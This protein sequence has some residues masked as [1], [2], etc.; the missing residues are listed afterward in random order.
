[1]SLDWDAVATHLDALAA[2]TVWGEN[3]IPEPGQRHTLSAVAR[4]IRGGQRALLLAD[5]VGMG[6]TLIAAALITCVRDAGGRSAVVI[7]PGLGAQWQSE[8]RRFIP[9]DRTLSP[10]RSFWTFREGYS[11]P[12]DI[13]DKDYMRKRR[14]SELADRRQQRQLPSGTWRDEQ[15]LLLSHTFGRLV[16]TSGTEVEYQALIDAVTKVYAGTRRYRRDPAEYSYVNLSRAA[17][18]QILSGLSA[19]DRRRLVEKELPGCSV[20]EGVRHIVAK[21]LGPFDLIVIDEAHKSRGAESSLSRVIGKLV[22]KTAGAFHLGMTATPV[23]LDASQW[24]G[25]LDRLGVPEETLLV[26]QSA[27]DRYVEAV[28]QLQTRE[29]LTADAVDRFALVARD[30]QQTLSPWVLRRDKREDSFLASFCAAHGSHRD[31]SPVEVALADM[32]LEWK[33]A[34]IATE[35]L[36][37]LGEHQLSPHERR[38]RLSLPDGRGI[39]EVDGILDAGEVSPANARQRSW[40]GLANIVARGGY[41]A[42]Y[43]H[44]AILRATSE[45]ETAVSE[46]QKV[47]VFGRFTKPMRALT[48]LLDAREM[49]RR[50]SGADTPEN[51]WP[52]SKLGKLSEERD[53]ALQSALDDRQ[54]N[55]LGLGRDEIEARLDDRARIHES[56]RRSN[57]DAMRSEIQQLASG[58]PDGTAAALA[59]LWRPH[60]D[61]DIA[62]SNAALLAALENQRASEDQ[63]LPWTVDGLLNAWQGL[64]R[65]IAGSGDDVD[66]GAE[67]EARFQLHLEDFRGPE[68]H[69]ARLMYGDTA[70]QTRRLLQASFNRPGVAPQV[71]VVQSSVGR[72][73]L[74]LHTACRVVVMLHLE[75]NPAYMEQQIGRVDRID[76]LWSRDAHAFPKSGDD[77]EAAPR[78]SIRP[79]VV[80]GT[81]DDRHWAV[82]KSRWNSM[83]AQLNGEILPDV[84]C[85]PDDRA[86]EALI[87]QA[88]AAAPDFSPSPG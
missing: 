35:A 39:T 23:E 68:G 76:S 55:P 70:P 69:F 78:I 15:V 59:R 31:I 52:Q 28:D 63:Y 66:E 82:L 30:F 84:E 10:L 43:S 53:A 41:A 79:V 45:I 4:R 46:G 88:R 58:E 50:V 81:Y 16:Q 18:E 51:R 33:R 19:S 12:E 65:E 49:V 22:W 8:L 64:A 38:L 26:I 7:P 2:A 36:S 77:P 61:E 72:E 1:M 87:R 32:P 34:F 44:P 80:S 48:L 13:A 54:V 85:A 17:A 20:D 73:G 42:L 56:A 71:L 6:K 57:L 47:L 21:A 75:W 62:G 9:M 25:T 37:L 3:T 14:A 67:F 60:G 11:V 5:E 83:R 40:A 86:R 29:A 24:S 27:I 74:N